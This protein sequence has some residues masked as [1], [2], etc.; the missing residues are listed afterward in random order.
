MA[1]EKHELLENTQKTLLLT[2]TICGQT[3][4]KEEFATKS[5]D[6]KPI[7]NKCVLHG[8]LSKQEISRITYCPLCHAFVTRHQGDIFC[9]SQ[10]K[11]GWKT[12]V[13]DL[14]FKYNN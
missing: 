2:C 1:K 12:T 3:K 7:C 6:N 5:I 14:A 8:G 4:P 13:A 11:C 10:Y 9:N